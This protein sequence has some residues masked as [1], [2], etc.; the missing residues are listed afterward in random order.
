[1]IVSPHRN[2]FRPEVTVQI[3]QHDF[4]NIATHKINDHK[5]CHDKFEFGAE[6]DE[7]QL[8]VDL[9]DELRRAR[10][11]Y[12]RYKDKTPIHAAI[13]ADT[14]SEGAALII[15]SECGNLLNELEQVHS[16][17]EEG[18]FEFAFEVDL[19][20][21]GFAGLDVVGEVDEGGDVD[22]K[23]AEDGADDIGI[24]DVRL[25]PFF[26]EAFDRLRRRVS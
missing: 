23:L 18:G 9:R 13:F 21:P 5:T 3:L 10:E 1:M 25:G 4:D 8:L 7:F 22:G 26:G 12:A 17:I 2:V 6:G 11:C 20:S 19:F 14:F 24:E 16:A 15:Y